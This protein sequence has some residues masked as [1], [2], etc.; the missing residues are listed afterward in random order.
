MDNLKNFL[1]EHKDDMDFE[2]PSPEVWQKLNKPAKKVPVISIKKWLYTAA[3]CVLLTS[4]LVYLMPG[5]NATNPPEIA[6]INEPKM[7]TVIDIPS[8]K[9]EPVTEHKEV[10]LL[11]EHK[12]EQPTIK[13]K[14]LKEKPVKTI[15]NEVQMA[16][17]SIDDNFNKILNA[18][19]NNINK[20]PIYSASNDLFTGFKTHYQQL[21]KDEKQLKKDIANYGIDEQLL[22]QLIFINQQKLNLLKDLQT[23]ISKVNNNTP[24][25]ERNNQHYLKM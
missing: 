19:L 20:T 14:A 9:A 8:E 22:Q 4:G 12:T 6:V 1:D 25:Q 15:N 21:E 3:A 11:A 5:K 16:V 23:E 13:V 17:K 10:P 2:S 24:A 7:D 18:Q